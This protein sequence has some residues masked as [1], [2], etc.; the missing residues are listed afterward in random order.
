MNP[1]APARYPVPI[2][3][4]PLRNVPAF[5]SYKYHRGVKR[6]VSGMAQTA[7][8][9]MIAQVETLTNCAR[10]SKPKTIIHIYNL[11]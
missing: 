5:E 9:E 1:T 3:A 8:E 4:R 7:V 2:G 11:D 10:V 6:T